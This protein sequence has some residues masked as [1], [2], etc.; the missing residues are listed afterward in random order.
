MTEVITVDEQSLEVLSN[1]HQITYA[2]SLDDE[3][4]KEAYQNGY[5][6]IKLTKHERLNIFIGVGANVEAILNLGNL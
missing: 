3:S 4:M 1:I 6:N 2:V 5:D